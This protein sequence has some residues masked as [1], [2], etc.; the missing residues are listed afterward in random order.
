MLANWS[1]TVYRL[2]RP[3]DQ[4]GQQPGF[5][6]NVL[7]TTVCR[8][9][10]TRC[11]KSWRKKHVQPAL[12]WPRQ[13]SPIRLPAYLSKQRAAPVVNV[14][15][16]FKPEFQPV[17]PLDLQSEKHTV[18]IHTPCAIAMQILTNEDMNQF[19]GDYNTGPGENTDDSPGKV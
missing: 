19:T 8:G 3:F 4:V 16:I 11:S 7:H 18:S 14:N 10:L 15:T 13:S 1:R 5:C 2:H 9:Q 17:P 12:H 6:P